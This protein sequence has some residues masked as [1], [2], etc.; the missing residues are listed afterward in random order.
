[1]KFLLFF[2]ALSCSTFAMSQ[3][4]FSLSDRSRKTPE[5]EIEVQVITQ[6]NLASTS[7]IWISKGVHAHFHENHT[8]HVLVLSGTASMTVNGNLF[9]IATGDLV[10]I[11]KGAVHE[12]EVTSQEDL[13]VLSIQAPLF[14]GKDRIFIQAK[15]GG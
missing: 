3:Y 12:L 8:E 4:Q 15:K 7:V 1:M 6:D 10:F 11:P 9:S 2:I 13:K 5:K 14:M